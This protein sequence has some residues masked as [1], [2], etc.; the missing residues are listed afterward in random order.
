MAAGSRSPRASRSALPASE[1]VVS[2]GGEGSSPSRG[3]A[4][5]RPRTGLL[6]RVERGDLMSAECPSRA[7][8][9]H[10]T[11]RWGVLLLVVL[12]SGTHRFSDL[13][14]KVGGVSEKMLAQ[15]LQSLESDGFVR[16]QAHP[17]MPPKVDYSLTELG[18]EVAGRV[19][20]LA[21]WIEDNY[22]RIE[23]QRRLADVA[24]NEQTRSSS[25]RL[26]HRA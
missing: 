10:V 26:V 19:Q 9:M 8:L 7:V 17:V 22:P 18:V 4:P 1:A 5:R 12:L 25:S 2:S 14:R 24:A 21:D 20:M 6:G 16:R 15:T 11:S 13:R 3:A 23:A